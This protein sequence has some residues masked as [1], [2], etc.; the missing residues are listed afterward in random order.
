M[1]NEILLEE[2]MRYYHG[3]VLT[4][5]VSNNAFSFHQ[6]RQRRLYV[7]PLIRGTP[8]DISPGTEVVFCDIFDG[9]ERACAGLRQWVFW[10]T[11]DRDVFFFDNHNHAF[12]FWAWGLKCG[13]VSPEALLVHVDQHK[14]TRAAEQALEPGFWQTLSLA[15]I[16]SYVNT[17]LNVGNFIPPALSCGMFRKA[18]MVDHD[19]AF[20]CNPKG[21]KI[22][23]LDLDIFAAEMN[24]IPYEKKMTF[25]RREIVASRLVTVATS[26]Y[27]MD[28]PRAVE[29]IGE[30]FG[31]L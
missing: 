7:P 5:P 12:A 11:R 27:F 10:R 17:V 28:Q 20:E 18:V 23:D 24:Y 29:L 3:F 6:R 9:G 16:C 21:E 19:Q 2:L 1:M 14:D 15:E 31:F 22:L 8:A 25:I 30:I 26:P 4:D 13:R